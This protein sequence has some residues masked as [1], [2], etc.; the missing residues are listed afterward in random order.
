MIWT[1]H[2]LLLGTHI[3]SAI[4]W[5]GGVLFI[6]WGVFPAVRY[7]TYENQRKFFLGEIIA[8]IFLGAVVTTL[9]YLVQT[10]T[11][12]STVIIVSSL[13]SMLIA[14]MML[15]RNIRDVKKDIEFRVTLG[16]RSGC[17]TAVQEL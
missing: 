8:A 2:Q 5:V 3:F 16:Y 14:S 10:Q 15:T 12:D 1:L 11:I 13:F 7:F 6:G 9:A 4:L 17:N